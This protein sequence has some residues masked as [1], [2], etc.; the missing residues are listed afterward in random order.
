[1]FIV[2][3]AKSY[4][5]FTADRSNFT[6]TLDN[7]MLSLLFKSKVVVTRILIDGYIN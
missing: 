1:M 6:V 2:L 4:F 3:Q 7:E 5:Y